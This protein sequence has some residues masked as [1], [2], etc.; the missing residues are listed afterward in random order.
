[1][2]AK[3]EASKENSLL[4]VRRIASGCR[5]VVAE[6]P[7]HYFFV[8]PENLLTDWTRDKIIEEVTTRGIPC[9]QGSCSEVYLEKAFDDTPWR[10]DKRLVN[11]KELGETSIMMLVHPSLTDGEIEK[12]CDV[13]NEV[14]SM[15]S[16]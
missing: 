16:K 9:F 8:K 3:G 14:L 2:R 15:A 1:M 7:I 13:L 5:E 6:R 11:A 12:S 4:E 10:P